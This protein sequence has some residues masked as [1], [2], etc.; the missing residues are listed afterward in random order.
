MTPGSTC[1][2]CHPFAIAGTVYPTGHE[3]TNCWGLGDPS[4][5]VVVYD[6]VGRMIVM[7]LSAAG[8]FAYSGTI[9]PPFVAGVRRGSSERYMFTPQINPDCNACHT[10]EGLLDAPGRIVPPYP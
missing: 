3:E 5:Q 9:T 1:L 7:D 8:N 6:S 2:G 4:V 10:A